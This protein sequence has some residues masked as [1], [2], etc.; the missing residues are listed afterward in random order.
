MLITHRE[1]YDMLDI[2]CEKLKKSG[3]CERHH[4]NVCFTNG[5]YCP[6]VFKNLSR[7]IF[8][9]TYAKTRYKQ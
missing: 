9:I 7:E 2:Q 8:N 4:D 5:L 6:K 3:I 1:F